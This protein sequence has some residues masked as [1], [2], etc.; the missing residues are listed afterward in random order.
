MNLLLVNEVVLIGLFVIC[1]DMFELDLS[2][3]SILSSLVG[4]VFGRNSIIFILGVLFVL[5]CMSLNFKILFGEFFIVFMIL[6]IDFL[7]V[8]SFLLLTDKMISFVS[9]FAFRAIDEF[10]NVLMMILGL[11][12][13]FVNLIVVIWL[14]KILNVKSMLVMMFVEMINARSFVGLL[15]NKFGSFFGYG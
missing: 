14:Y 1:L 9:M 11:N 3:T 6:F 10:V 5:I 2:L 8:V 13:C 7:F 15:R 4:V 12:F